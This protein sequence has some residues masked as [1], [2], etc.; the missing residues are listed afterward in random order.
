MHQE[1]QWH[2]LSH[3]F[4]HGM[5][6][7]FELHKKVIKPVEVGLWQ[8]PIW[9]L[10]KN[11]NSMGS[12]D[13]SQLESVAKGNYVSVTRIIEL[14]LNSELRWRWCKILH[15]WSSERISSKEEK[16]G[17]QQIPNFISLVPHKYET[18]FRKRMTGKWETYPLQF[19]LVFYHEVLNCTEV[20]SFWRPW[21][22]IPNNL[23][24]ND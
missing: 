11:T 23:I 1:C 2:W 20:L 16:Y 14:D 9:R 18:L 6:V 3:I 15:L 19:I 17:L 12:K 22:P 4:I 8:C 21:S 5:C 24:D 7:H 13:D 10:I